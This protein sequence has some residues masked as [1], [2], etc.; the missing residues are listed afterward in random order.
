[1]RAVLR[2]IVPFARG[3]R[4]AAARG[5]RRRY[6][7]AAALPVAWAALDAYVW[8]G[9]ACLGFAAMAFFL[10]GRPG[11]R[12]AGLAAA[13]AAA[14]FLFSS[15]AS[16]GPPA[17][18]RGAFP[19]EGTVRGFPSRQRGIQFDLETSRG[20]FRVRAGDPGCA[21]LPG[22]KLRLIARCVPPEIPTNPGQFDYPAYLRSLNL[23]GV[24]KADSLS[25]L[26]GPGPWDRLVIGARRA[27]L[28]G[29]E[30]AVPPAQA[31]LLKAALIGD[32]DGL[33]PALVD[34]F[35]AS[36]MLHILAISGQHVGII[37]LIFL[38][39]GGLLGVPRKAACVA[40]AALLALY[41]PVCGG[42]VSVLRAALM[43]ACGLPGVL[44]ERPGS[45]LN[46]LGWAAA[47]TLA[48]MPW[49]ILSLGFQLSY[50]ATF[51][52]ILY[53][54]PL[55]GL[56]ARWR[57]R[58]AAAAYVVSTPLLSLA[59]FLGA[60]PVLAAA[61]HLCA[62]S[63][64]L[65]NLA[66]IG[67]SSAMLASACLALLAA[68]SAALAACFGACAG[69]LGSALA[70]CVHAL[71]RLPG[72]AVPIPGMPLPWGLALILAV[73]I[74][75][76]ALRVRRGRV[77]ALACAALFAGYGACARAR[78][79]F[80]PGEAVFLDVGQGDAAV[81]RLPGAVVLIDAGPEPAG[82][83]VI[84]PYLRS[85][86]IGRIDLAIVT[87]PD[88]DHYG[89]LAY[90][91]GRMR[92]GRFLYP[93]LDADTRAWAGLKRELTA[94]GIPIDTARRGQLL[95]AG[96]G[97][98]LRVLSPE[99]AAQY[100]DRNDNSVTTLLRLGSRTALFTGDLGPEAEARLMDLEP[101]RLAGAILKVPHH[102]SDKSNPVPFLQAI[103]P[104]QSLLS[105]GRV[106]RFGH[107]GPATVA[108]LRNLGSALYCTARDGAVSL[109]GTGAWARFLPSD[110]SLIPR[111]PPRHA[112]GR[113]PGLRP[114]PPGANM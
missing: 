107:P 97:D 69:G 4:A 63:S 74:F 15:R 51:L 89:G 2:E 67:L 27:L 10:E 12:L 30:R 94:R 104:P 49:D 110:T 20:G 96:G 34:D 33:D 26:A 14:A 76:Y 46:N 13:F 6:G 40:T 3:L 32:T 75:P 68:P 88:L 112:R 31:P 35:K 99:Y 52:L 11:P 25:V 84:L 61:S 103:R 81:L 72:A 7:L 87:H 92:I 93:G 48:F 37:A 43:F 5:Y 113:P 98:T 102:G 65:G 109:S 19:L 24:L 79:A 106:N 111:A 29:L 80:S 39:I 71:A 28:R 114:G 73:L 45:A 90:L 86:G 36:G 16:A 83:E 58:R 101:R 1:M 44:W 100:A 53:A 108:A 56:L 23:R 78:A 55:A 42:Q 70:A 60:Y 77:L 64:L 62:P 38:Q 18:P 41:V 22:Q 85:Q 54:R 66:T 50:A 59:L 95:F 57:V 17:W 9:W 21:I 8:P 47:L 105:C 82:R 91:A